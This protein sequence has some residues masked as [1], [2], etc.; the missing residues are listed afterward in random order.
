MRMNHFACMVSLP[1]FTIATYAQ[2]IVS[3]TVKNNAS[4]EPI[5]AASITVKGTVT[6]TFTDDKGNFKLTS[7]KTP[8]FVLIIT[9]VGFE[10]KEMSISSAGSV[11]IT[12]SPTASL[13][14]EIVV[15]ASRVPER[16]L[17]SPV[18]VE[19]VSNASIRVAPATSYYDI[20]GNLKGVDMTTSSL[21]FK[22]PSTRG[23]NASGNTRLNQIVDGMDNQAPGLNFSVGSVIGLT[24]L[25]VESMELLSGASSALYGPGGMNG[26]ILINSKDPFKYPGLSAQVKGGIMNINS[27]ARDASAYQDYSIRWAQKITD[28]FAFK[29]G[30][31][32][33]RAI[34]WVAYDSSDYDVNTYSVKPGTRSSDPNYNGV[35]VYGDE[36]TLDIRSAQSPFIQGVIATLPA[37]QQPLVT[38]IMS[39][40][41]SSPQNVSRTG[42]K[43]A[44]IIDPVTKNI[45]LSGGLYYK[46]KDDLMASFSGYW[47]TGNTVYTGSD[48][49]GL[50]NLKMGQY[51]LELKSKNW[52]LRGYTTQENSGDS[53]NATV[54]TR[55]TNEAWKPSYNAANPTGSWYPQY[56][57]AFVQGAVTIWQQAYQAALAAGQDQQ[58]AAA[59]AEA[60]VVANSGALNGL[61]RGYADKGMPA[62]GST[63]FQKYFNSVITKPIPQGGLFVDRSDLYMVEGQ[64]NLTDALNLSSKGT[65]ILAGA[66]WKQYV[67]NSQGTIFADT[68]GKIHINEGGGYAQISQKLLGDVVKLT[69]SVRYDK[70]ENFKGKFTPRFSAVM[71]VAKDQNIR[72]SYQTAYRFPTT[73]NQWINLQTGTAF[74]IGG[75]P[76]LREGHHFN[77]NPVYTQDSYMTFVQSGNPSNLKVQQFNEYKPETSH[78]YEIGYKGLFANKLLIDMYGYYAHY[79]DFLGRINVFQSA[80]SDGSV[81]GLSNPVIYSVAVNS[82]NSVNTYGYG[83]SLEYQLRNNFSITGNFYSDEISDVPANFQAQFNTPKYRTNIGVANNGFGWEKRLGFNVVYRWQDAY[84]NESTFINGNVN[85]FST[86]DAQVSFKLPKI[87]SLIK[88]G[89][90]NITNHYYINSYGNPRIGALYYLSV[91][92]NVL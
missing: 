30:A 43:E 53:Y 71:K 19:R 76:Q 57:G 85:A 74:L 3:G 32:Y 1:F 2:T 17:E 72:L 37:S 24:E 90:T 70:N 14:S 81:V 65:D 91:A 82:P 11:S 63:E 83:I 45:K 46:I 23:F 33:V 27:P 25:D 86:L 16:I 56:A 59:T 58:Q 61:A 21:T 42:Y 75:L 26:T 68:T 10:S 13:G 4:G 66:N 40:F 34:D 48:R 88:L 84:Y 69:A 49:Y 9:S 51:K 89:G 22:T 60:A 79:K 28:K 92:Y 18:S 67:L 41:L 15:S 7:K 87:K 55:L 52:F 6:G 47:G 31:Q 39:P 64:Y 12:L 50:K 36:T 35:N 29:I 62:A 38:Q 78:S 77:T 8:P 5:T 80:N 54:S 20:I 73:Q 44:D